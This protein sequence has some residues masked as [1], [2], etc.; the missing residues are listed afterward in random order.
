MRGNHD[1][2]TQ[3][4]NY[5]LHFVSTHMLITHKWCTSTLATNAFAAP[6]SL[7]ASPAFIFCFRRVTETYAFAEA[8]LV[9]SFCREMSAA[10]VSAAAG[11]ATKLSA[12]ID[13]CR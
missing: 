3:V 2:T 5:T 1:L 6:A 12:T 10:W 11:L 13:C 9:G 4:I 8:I 7:G